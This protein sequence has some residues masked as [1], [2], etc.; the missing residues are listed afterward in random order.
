MT[1]LDQRDGARLTAL[2]AER[3][4]ANAALV[5]VNAKWAAAIA[6][7]HAHGVS[8]PALARHIDVTHQRIYQLVATAV[9]Q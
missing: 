6:D 7:V 3:A 8:A 2:A 9:Q 4:A 5:A 1:N